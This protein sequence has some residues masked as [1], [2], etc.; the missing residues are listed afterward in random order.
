MP[1]TDTLT[2]SKLGL[3]C[4]LAA[5]FPDECLSPLSYTYSQQCQ[6][7]R[8][9]AQHVKKTKPNQQPSKNPTKTPTAFWYILNVL[10]VSIKIEINWPQGLWYTGGVSVDP[11]STACTAWGV[12]L[13]VTV[14]FSSK[15]WQIMFSWVK[16]TCHKGP[17]TYRSQSTL[18][19]EKGL[20]QT[21]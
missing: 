6:S 1:N 11:T 15:C 20:S 9:L 5:L 8:F 4:P 12:C 19:W 21:F 3:P 14:D 2:T 16:A 17:L 13:N 10:R 7:I 18:T